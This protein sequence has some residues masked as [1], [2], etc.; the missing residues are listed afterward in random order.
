M[1]SWS[2]K[3]PMRDPDEPLDVDAITDLPQALEA[4]SDRQIA[5]ELLFAARLDG[6]ETVGQLHD[7]IERLSG[8]ERR[9]LL[10]RARERVGLDTTETIDARV[11][12]EV[13]TRNA[14]LAGSS[15]SPW[16]ICAEPTC[17]EIPINDLGAPIPVDV[18]RWWCR[19]HRGQSQ[20]ADMEWRPLAIRRPA[21]GAL[22]PWDEVE[23]ANEAAAAASRAALREAELAERQ[24][25]AEELA[26]RDRAARARVEREV[27][28]GVP[29]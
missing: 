15:E 5:R 29:R 8:P 22:I 20:P 3:L 4:G 18:R 19:A 25:E 27:P 1:T 17:R 26:E 28:P 9:Q 21:S 24:T 11:R 2:L 16:Q 6:I 7:M 12:V 14:R 23:Q 10:D 13:A